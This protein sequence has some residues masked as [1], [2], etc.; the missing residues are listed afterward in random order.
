MN[1]SPAPVPTRATIQQAWTHT[2]SAK[3]RG[4]AL[5]RERGWLLAW[6]ENSWL[7]LLNL[8]GQRQAQVRMT[9]P[10]AAACCADDGS[11]IVAAGAGG[12]GRAWCFT[13]RTPRSC[14]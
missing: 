13:W 4:L 8:A 10:V 12:V 11:A 9:T 14:W 3:P 7:Y 5:A 1:V 2:L 6:D